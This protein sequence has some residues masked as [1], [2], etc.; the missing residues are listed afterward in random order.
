MYHF[1]GNE[2]KTIQQAQRAGGSGIK[3]S[4][5]GRLGGATCP[6]QNGFREGRVPLHT[7][8][9][10]RLRICKPTTTYGITGLSG[11]ITVM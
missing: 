10:R 8:R 7:L 4:C 1:D 11:S 2:E 3:V 6:E 9:A 5:A